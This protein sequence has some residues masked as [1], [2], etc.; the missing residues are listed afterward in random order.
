[1]SDN[2]ITFFGKCDGISVEQL[3]RYGQFNMNVK[4]FHNQYEIFYIVEGERQFFFDN[5]S[6]N[7]YAGDLTIL[8]TNLV[9]TTCSIS[10]EDKGYNR[11]ILYID[12]EKMCE[13]DRKYPGLDIVSFIHNNYGIYHLNEELRIAFLN[14]YRDIRH[15]LTKK[16]AGYQSRIEIVTLYWLYK[17]LSLKKDSQQRHPEIRSVKEASAHNISA[18]LEKNYTSNLSLDAI[19]EELFMSKY[20]ICRIFKEYTGFT[21]T[22]YINTLRIKKATQLLEKSCDSISDIATELG[23]ESASYFER[24]FKKIM[25]VTPLK[26]RKTHQSVTIEHEELN[27]LDDSD[28]I[29]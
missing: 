16:A 21:I 29:D 14:L 11:V 24:T 27:T 13:F 1:M 20:Y 10:S 12:Y 18:Y 15:E 22:E 6:Y 9:H 4:H 2:K 8:D 17:L 25:N 23:F 7:A 5:K 3:I 19:A 26:Y 28:Y